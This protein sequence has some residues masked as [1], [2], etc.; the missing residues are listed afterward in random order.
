MP[1]RTRRRDPDHRRGGVRENVDED[2]A[3][4]GT[5]IPDADPFAKG[6]LT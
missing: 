1:Q 2:E 6:P 4:S 3:M 5:I